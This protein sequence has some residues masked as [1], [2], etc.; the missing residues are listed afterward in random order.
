ME[1]ETRRLRSGMDEVL[2]LLRAK[3]LG[4]VKAIAKKHV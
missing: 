2:A 1:S 4:G 3:A